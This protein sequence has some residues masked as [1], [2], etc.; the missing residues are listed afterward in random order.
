LATD[1][2]EDSGL[3]RT[4]L[5]YEPLIEAEGY[6][7]S[8]LDMQSVTN[9]IL[10]W[11]HD[12]FTITENEHFEL[13]HWLDALY[14]HIV[15]KQPWS[16][17]EAL[18]AC[19]DTKASGFPYCKLY[20]PYKGQVKKHMT[21]DDLENDFINYSQLFT[22]TLKDECRKQGKD[23]RLFV[24][25]NMSMV[26]VGNR[27]FGAQNEA[28]AQCSEDYPIKI[29]LQSPGAGACK[30][31]REF[32]NAKGLCY[33]SDG[34]ANDAHFSLAIAR[35]IRDFRS[36]HLPAEL[37]KL[38][39][40]YYDMA[41]CMKA[42]ARGAVVNLFG[43]PTGHTNTASDNSF[44][45]LLICMLHAMRNGMNFE[46]FKEVHLAI[47]GDD[48][49]WRTENRLFSPLELE[50]TFNSVGMY[51]ES[52]NDGST[53]DTL[54]FCGMHPIVREVLGVKYLLYHYG[55][56]KLLN[57]MNFIKKT[58]TPAQRLLKL[59]SI[60]TLMFGKKETFDKLKEVVFLYASNNSDSL[61]KSD[62]SCL[63]FLN[64]LAQL[65]LHT[66][67]ESS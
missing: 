44:G 29:G 41:Y 60:T 13:I 50:K 67:L 47:M 62:T 55:E 43:Q 11:Q 49:M 12:Q 35:V 24:P 66:S 17:E 18:E 15:H 3:P 48:M 58:M 26:V 7:I 30:L 14:G 42:N 4:K 31:W 9:G 22:V 52:P 45:Y 8:P 64:E 33:Q 32:Y 25:A 46:E 1:F 61:T 53:F 16:K 10:K 63:G 39:N 20:G 65:R 28:I 37:R 19:V 23:S 40:R 54:T 21:Y 34:A 59:M 51:L 57:S 36:K 56:E 27:L 5:T 6:G 2:V 38:V